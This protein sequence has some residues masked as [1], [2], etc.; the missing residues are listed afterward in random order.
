MAPPSDRAWPLQNSPTD[1]FWGSGPDGKGRNELG[2]ALMRLRAAL[3]DIEAQ[4][5]MQQRGSRK[6][7]HA[8]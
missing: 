3:R 1:A 2:K 7:G 6:V 5:L 4:T 8:K